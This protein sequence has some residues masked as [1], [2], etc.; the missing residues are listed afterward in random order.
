MLAPAT[1]RLC[2][3]AARALLLAAAAIALPAQQAP[4]P[5]AQI[6]A[7]A[8]SLTV[9]RDP[10]RSPDGEPSATPPLRKQGEGYVLHTDVEEVVLNCTVLDGKRLVPDLKKENFQVLEDGVKQTLISF[11]HTDLP[12]STPLVVGNSGTI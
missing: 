2:N 12:V 10:V 3:N 4:A 6:Q 1:M 5:P 7:Q 9:D 11:Q 8:P